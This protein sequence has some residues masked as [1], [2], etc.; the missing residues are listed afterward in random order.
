[1]VY[2]SVDATDVRA[3]QA[4]VGRSSGA[5]AAAAPGAGRISR[6]ADPFAL[7]DPSTAL[8]TQDAISAGLPLAEFSFGGE[9][10]NASR[11]GANAGP[12]SVPASPAQPATSSFSPLVQRRPSPALGGDVV[13]SGSPFGD[14]AARYGSTWPRSGER[15][16]ALPFARPRVGPGSNSVQ[17]EFDAGHEPVEMPLV[18]PPPAIAREVDTAWVE[19][20]ISREVTIDE[21]HSQVDPG[22]DNANNNAPAPEPNIDEITEKVWQRIRRKLRIERERSRGIG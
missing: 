15:T 22:N 16:E 6:T 11:E 1:M 7:A 14:S 9:T 21:V 20:R 18:S 19:Y 8:T 5:D 13:S 2:R 17:R 4:L 3:V 12:T 10:R